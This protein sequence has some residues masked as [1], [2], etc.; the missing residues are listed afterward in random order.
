[1]PDD[2][3]GWTWQSLSDFTPGVYDFTFTYGT[4]GEL[5]PAGPGAAD[6]G[7]TYCCIGLP[8]GGLGPLP[9]LTTSYTWPAGSFPGSVT[10]M[11]ITGMTENPGLVN[12]VPEI[13][14]MTEGDDGTN[15]YLL[16]YSSPIGGTTQT[17][18]SVSATTTTGIFGSPYPTWDRMNS[19]Y[20]NPGLPVLVFPAAVATDPNGTTGHMFVYPNPSSRSS[21][22]A[23]DM[24]TVPGTNGVTGQLICYQNRAMGLSAA[25]ATY[26]AGGGVQG[27]EQ[28][29]YTDPANSDTYG[30]QQTTLVAENPWGYGAA[31]SVSAGE[32]FLVKKRQGG[33][34]MTGDIYQPTATYLPGVQPTGDLYGKAE[35]TDQGLI[36]CAEGAGAWIWNG[37]NTSQKLSRQVRNDFYDCSTNVIA[38]NNYGFFVKR[39]GDLVLFSNN[40]VYSSLT[41]SWWVLYPQ[42]TVTNYT[43]I[44]FFHYDNGTFGYQMYASPLT[45]TSASN[46]Y[47]YK[48]DMQTPA[49]HYQWQSLPLNVAGPH[50]H[51][52]DIRQITLKVS[53]TANNNSTVT[54]TVLSQGSVAWTSPATAVP[55]NVTTLRFNVGAEG[56]QAPAIRINVDNVGAGDTAL[57]HELAYAVRQRAHRGVSNA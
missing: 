9:A 33:V 39:W 20:T 23:L 43:G 25:P 45:V 3:R 50:D 34:I 35:P 47:L 54:V 37:G 1:V 49:Q 17:V 22:S 57:I 4:N 5:P 55:S 40:F 51:V 18:V 7:F 52:Y 13:V 15:H 14:W 26:P 21:F 38:S 19:T 31:G 48:F 30:D 8:Q 46:P 12:G 32:L 56:L 29:N 42:T 11:Y 2:P 36:Y 16:A 41:N 6:A 24:I 10:T 27:N 44:K 28:I 53:S